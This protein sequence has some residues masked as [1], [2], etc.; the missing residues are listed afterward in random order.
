MQSYFG[1]FSEYSSFASVRC[2]LL[3]IVNMY[4]LLGIT[5]APLTDLASY[6]KE[7]PPTTTDILSSASAAQ[8]E[9]NCPIT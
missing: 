7:F 2:R 9:K 5:L 1:A 8:S 4:S 3:T 6:H